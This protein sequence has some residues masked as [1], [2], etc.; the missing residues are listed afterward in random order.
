M[1]TENTTKEIGAKL[2]NAVTSIYDVVP[3]L[4]RG[5][6]KPFPVDPLILAA[7]AG[8]YQPSEGVIVTI[9]VDGARIFAQV[10]KQGEYELK[11]RSNNQFYPRE[12][13]AE[14]TF[15]KNA[16]GEVDRLVYVINGVT[17]EAKKVP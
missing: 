12:F 9:R 10:S 2:A 7:Y 16:S 6:P 15:Y 4:L 3:Q 8:K 5:L 13:E 1:R 14:I 11:A 17:Y